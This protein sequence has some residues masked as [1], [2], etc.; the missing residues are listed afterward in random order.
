MDAQDAHTHLATADLENG[1]EA[2]ISVEPPK[3]SQQAA[4][5]ASHARWKSFKAIPWANAVLFACSLAG[6]AVGTWSL[7]GAYGTRETAGYVQGNYH[8]TFLPHAQMHACVQ[9]C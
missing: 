7:F 4:A 5:S 1:Q 8:L 6:A 2:D 9:V 3:E